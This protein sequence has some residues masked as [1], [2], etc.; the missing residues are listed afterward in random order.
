MRQQKNSGLLQTC[1]NGKVMELCSS[2]C[3]RAIVLLN[4]LPTSFFLPYQ[5]FFLSGKL[6]RTA[7]ERKRLVNNLSYNEI[8]LAYS[9]LCL[10]LIN[11]Q[12]QWHILNA[13]GLQNVIRFHITSNFIYAVKKLQ[14]FFLHPLSQNSWISNG[15]MHK[16]F[17]NLLKCTLIRQ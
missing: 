8:W 4:D 1:T 3:L 2:P 9:M 11:L 14:P 16:G 13:I 6:Q 10:Q 15:I 5:V 7:W 12:R 17:T